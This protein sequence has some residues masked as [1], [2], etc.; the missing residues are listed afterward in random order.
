MNACRRKEGDIGATCFN[1]D[2]LPVKHWALEMAQRH[3]L[4][5]DASKFGKVRAACMGPLTSFD[6]LITDS[7]PDEEFIQYAQ[8][9]KISLVW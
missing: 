9:N 2:E 6:T 8:Q 3:V 7:R 4:V 5:A 1:L